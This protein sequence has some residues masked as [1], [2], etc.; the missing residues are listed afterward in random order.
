[1]PPP[2]LSL[3]L[4]AMALCLVCAPLS[5]QSG[6]VARYEAH[7]DREMN[8]QPH[9]VGPLVTST[10]KLEQEL[11]ADFTRSR[12]PAGFDTWNLGTGKGVQLVPLPRTQLTVMLPPFINHTQPGQKDG[13]GDL[14]FQAKYR[15]FGRNEQ[16]G[17]AIITAALNAT[18]P[19]GKNGNGLCCATVSPLLEAGKGWGR[20]DVV[21]AL[22]GT[23]PVSGTHTLGRSTAWNSVA[24][25]RAAGGAG[26]QLWF[27]VESNATFFSGG[28]H[29]G[30]TQ[31]FILPGITFR[32]LPLS[33]KYASGKRAI[34]SIGIGEQVAT[35]RFHTYNHALILTLHLPF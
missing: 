24:Q 33:R 30:E 2:R 3:S 4:C 20:F 15:I 11:R 12:N 16:H 32:R 13:F 27:A 19:T 31:N 34:T 1:M 25:W 18:I 23:L 10:P 35:T 29:D 9:W 17:N 28:P 14:G 8:L 22:S 5:A 6:W 21:T 7:V 26:S